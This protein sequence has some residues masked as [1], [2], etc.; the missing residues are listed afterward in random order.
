VPAPSGFWASAAEDVKRNAIAIIGAD[1]ADNNVI[2]RQVPEGQVAKFML[3]GWRIF[4]V[5]S[6][7]LVLAATSIDEWTPSYRK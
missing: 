2:V 6:L 3:D 1:N 5:I 4:V 7:S